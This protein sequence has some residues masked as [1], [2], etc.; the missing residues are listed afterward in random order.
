[1]RLRSSSIS[2]VLVALAMVSCSSEEDAPRCAAD[3]AQRCLVNQQGCTPDAEGA[4]ECVPCTSGTR[5]NAEGL[6]ARIP[7]T[8]Q[9]HDFDEVVSEPG[10]ELSGLCRSWTLDN[11]EELWVHAVELEQDE[12]SHHSNWTFVPDTL[13]L[14][15]DGTWP[16]AER[17]YHQLQAAVAGGVLYAQ[18]TQAARE[19][20]LFPEGAAVRIPPRSRIISDIHV[21]NA[22]PETVRGHARLS[23]YTI[24]REDVTIVLTP[25][26][27]DYHAL[28]IPPRATSRFVTTCDLASDF[29]AATERPFHIR[30]F[31][32]LPHTHELGTRV[33]LQ[34]IGG[35]RDGE[36]LVDVRGYNGEARGLLYEPPVD[37]AGITGL[38]FGCE[39]ENPRAEEVG[40][41]IGDQEMCEML[42]FVESAAAFESRVAETTSMRMDG[43]VQEF[44]G[45]CSNFVI[46]WEGR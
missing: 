10:Q 42:G 36:M 2:L 3:D 16:C 17:D 28:T 38:R 14:G 46:P 33:F 30:L 4:A 44:S 6:C 7:G 18:S 25:F 20:Q 41:G 31:Y 43:D 19:V 29:E 5:A 23:I 34:A 12:A 11:D 22:T 15:P 8:A 39:F 27:I 21:L 26:H 45:E 9:T 13:Y 24:P 40:W 37:L 35:P 1:M 32:S